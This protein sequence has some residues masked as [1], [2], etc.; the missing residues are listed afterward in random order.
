MYWVITVET[1]DKLGKHRRL[2][3]IL[4]KTESPTSSVFNAIKRGEMLINQ[5]AITEEEY[6]LDPFDLKI[7]HI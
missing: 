6:R 2:E 1:S 3:M 4:V 7:R 5:L